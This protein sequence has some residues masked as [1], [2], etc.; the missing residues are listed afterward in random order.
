MSLKQEGSLEMI[1]NRGRM[2]TLILSYRGLMVLGGVTGLN[3]TL[4]LIILPWKMSWCEE[5]KRG[6]KISRAGRY[7]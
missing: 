4:C 7:E 3:K 5:E 1:G 2:C 6:E